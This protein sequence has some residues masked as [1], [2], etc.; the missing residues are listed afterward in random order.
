VVTPQVLGRDEYVDGSTEEL[1]QEFDPGY[2]Q[3]H[4]ALE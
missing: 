2:Q 4:Y 3:S 1:E